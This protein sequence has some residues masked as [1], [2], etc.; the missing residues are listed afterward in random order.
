MYHFLSTSL[1]V[2]IT[3]DVAM[4]YRA[5]GASAR[6]DI[7]SLREGLA[8]RNYDSEWNRLCYMEFNVHIHSITYIYMWLYLSVLSC[9]SL[10]GWYICYTQ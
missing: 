3:S 6:S 7:D 9:I 10:S 1:Y 4:L 2:I 8:T 5:S